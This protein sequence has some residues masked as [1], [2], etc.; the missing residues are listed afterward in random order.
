[1]LEHIKLIVSD[2]DGTLINNDGQVDQE[3]YEVKKKLD[4]KGIKFTVATGRNKEIVKELVDA[5]NITIPYICN[6]G[7]SI[8][9][10]QETVLEHYF[11]SSDLRK[12]ME[13]LLK[14]NYTFI[15]TGKEVVYRFNQNDL[16]DFYIKRLNQKITILQDKSIEDVCNDEVC[17]FVVCAD[18][19]NE[20][21]LLAEE[22]NLFMPEVKF[23]Q[24]EGNIFTITSI[25]ADKGVAVKYLAEKYNIKKEE[26]VCFGDNYNDLFM[27]EVCGYPIAMKNSDSKIKTKAYDV[28]ESNNEN[29]VSK[30]IE[31]VILKQNVGE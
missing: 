15:V 30:Y 22:I 14:R 4:Q 19:L 24:S 10:H 5:L 7:G 25:H 6:N 18:D 16:L 8:I 17:K 21:L 26:I 28:C 23:I 1:M 12:I 3:I 20:T 27:F 13:E 9:H 2:L 31:Q 11:G 29:G